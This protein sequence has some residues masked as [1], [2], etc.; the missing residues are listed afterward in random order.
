MVV[1]VGLAWVSLLKKRSLL[2]ASAFLSSTASRHWT[3]TE[4]CLP[5]FSPAHLENNALIYYTWCTGTVWT[6]AW[7]KTQLYPHCCTSLLVS[8][9]CCSPHGG[10]IAKRHEPSDRRLTFTFS[11]HLKHALTILNH[12]WF[13]LSLFRIEWCQMGNYLSWSVVT[14]T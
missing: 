7:R 12:L 2:T 13:V 4:H 1:N 5:T 8:A 14:V 10:A 11:V 3:S 9:W 6:A